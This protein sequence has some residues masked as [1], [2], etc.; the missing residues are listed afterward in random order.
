MTWEGFSKNIVRIAYVAPRDMIGEGTLDGNT[1]STVHSTGHSLCHDHSLP[2][3]YRLMKLLVEMRLIYPTVD[4]G[5]LTKHEA[6]SAI[7][8]SAI[9][10]GLPRDYTKMRLRIAVEPGAQ[11]AGWWLPRVQTKRLTCGQCRLS[12][13]PKQAFSKTCSGWRFGPPTCNLQT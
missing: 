13:V 1:R 10:K 11:S 7:F 2:H 9:K 3:C 12:V 4:C 8:K 5:S 6:P